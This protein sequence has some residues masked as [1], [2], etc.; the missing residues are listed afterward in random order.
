MSYLTME[1]RF[2]KRTRTLRPLFGLAAVL[3]TA[4]TLGLGVVAPTTL[5]RVDAPAKAAAATMLAQGPTEVAI[6]PGTIKVVGTKTKAARASSPY[7]PAS[8]RRG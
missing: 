5:A 4:A 2:T 3:C 8:Y 6:L 1:N 7:M